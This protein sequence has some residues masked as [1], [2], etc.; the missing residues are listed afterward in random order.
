MRSVCVYQEPF[1]YWVRPFL[2]IV[3]IPEEKEPSEVIEEFLD[4][5]LPNDVLADNDARPYN[6]VVKGRY[7]FFYLDPAIVDKLKTLDP[8]IYSD[9]DSCNAVTS[10]LMLDV[11]RLF[12]VEE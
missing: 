7:E 11:C 3:D 12:K 1:D 6:E 4:R 8:Y 2:G 9:I 10:S 5:E